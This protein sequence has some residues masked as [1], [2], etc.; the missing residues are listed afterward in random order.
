MLKRKSN[1]C[2]EGRKGDDINAARRKKPQNWD[3][4]VVMKPTKEVA[5]ELGEQG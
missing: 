5:R 3:S 1:D 2:G 4:K